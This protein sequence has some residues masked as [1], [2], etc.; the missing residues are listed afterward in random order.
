MPETITASPPPP[1]PRSWASLGLLAGLVLGWLLALPGLTVSVPFDSS[2]TQRPRFRVVVLGATLHRYPEDGDWTPMRPYPQ[3]LAARRQLAF[4]SA[5][6]GG[7]VGGLV[8]R[9]ASPTAN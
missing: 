8:V 2:E 5:F 1:P 9:L 4:A 3:A 6:G 7:V